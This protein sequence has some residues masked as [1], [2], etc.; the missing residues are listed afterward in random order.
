L[1]SSIEAL[2]SSKRGAE[3]DS[4]MVP[5][6]SSIGLISSRISASP[7]RACSTP[8]TRVCQASSPTSQSNDSVWMARRLGTSRCSVI[9]PKEIRRGAYVLDVKLVFAGREDAKM[10]PSEDLWCGGRY[11]CSPMDPGQKCS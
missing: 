5:E 7:D 6:K 11:A 9:L 1:H 10:R 8:D 2:T 3:N 4:D